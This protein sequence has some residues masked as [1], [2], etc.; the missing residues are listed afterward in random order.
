MVTNTAYFSQEAMKS[1][2]KPKRVI[3][4]NELKMV[5]SFAF[6]IAL[7]MVIL[8]LRY[9]LH[10]YNAM[11]FE[12]HC[13]IFDRIL[14]LKE[15]LSKNKI[16]HRDLAARN[17]LVSKEGDFEI[18]KIADFGL[19]RDVYEQNWYKKETKGMLPCK[20]LAI[21]SLV[22]QVYTTKSDV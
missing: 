12:M 5:L 8:I 4:A 11:R 21:E 16:I 15:H 20:W 2:Q 3:E 13:M 14:D 1:T 6:Q 18:L 17:I 22:H 19:S 10:G 9:S 7:A